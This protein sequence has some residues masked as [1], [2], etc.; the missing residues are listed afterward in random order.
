MFSIIF[1]FNILIWT[2]NILQVIQT[3]SSDDPSLVLFSQADHGRVKREHAVWGDPAPDYSLVSFNG[4]ITYIYALLFVDYK[5]TDYYENDMVKVKIEVTRMVKEA[6]E[7]LY[8]LN[9]RI[10]IVDILPTMRSN[11]TLYSFDYYY[12]KRRNL[13]Y[14]NFVSLISYR[15]G[16]GLGFVNGMCNNQAIMQVGFYPHNP[17][18]MGGIFFHELAH[19][20]GVTHMNPNETLEV[21]NCGCPKRTFDDYSR[22]TSIERRT[23]CLKIP[24]V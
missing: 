21:P 11:L 7:Y 13:P 20:I 24:Y 15:Y 22:L 2:F 16:G 9:V 14:H 1:H 10:S 6:N 3:T 12:K 5:I 17:E 23:G 18:A 8:Q 19:L 4:T